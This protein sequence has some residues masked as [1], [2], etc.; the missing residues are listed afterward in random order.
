M[1]QHMK[2]MEFLQEAEQAR[3]LHALKQQQLAEYQHHN[4]E[5]EKYNLGP[6]GRKLGKQYAPTNLG[7]LYQERD[8][9][10]EV[11]G[12]G[13][14]QANS[15]NLAIQKATTDP[16]TRKRT[17][18]ASNLEKTLKMIDTKTITQ[19]SGP[20][21]ALQLKIDQAAD[22]AG[23][24][25]ERYLAYKDALGALG[26]AVGQVRQFLNDASSKEAA[27][28]LEHMTNPSSLGSS[29]EAAE[30]QLKSTL[31]IFANELQTY[32]GGLRSTR[33]HTGHGESIPSNSGELKPAS[34]MGTDAIREEIS[35]LKGA[36]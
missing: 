13:S 23:N 11:Y 20:K 8:Q 7:K 4:R 6:N 32:H 2:I 16:D 5:I 35:R 17:L 9:A 1:G 30:R 10:V 34:A 36:Q 24:P 3:K 14:P 25:P 15:Y 27:E 29:P 19:Y 33:E 28:K 21:G 31:G 22:L 26:P 12:E 18:F